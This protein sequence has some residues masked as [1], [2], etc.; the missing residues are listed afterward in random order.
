MSNSTRGRHRSGRHSAPKKKAASP[1]SFTALAGIAGV[2]SVIATGGSALPT[3]N[4]AVTKKADD[5][6]TMIPVVQAEAISV[7]AANRAQ[8]ASR[9]N[10]RDSLAEAQAAAQASTVADPAADLNAVIDTTPTLKSTDI[11]AIQ[12][13]A[14]SS[15]NFNLLV[16]QVQDDANQRAQLLV[17][18]QE[19]ARATAAE[20]EAKVAAAIEKAARAKQAAITQAQ[21]IE[22][23]GKVTIPI[24]EGYELSARFWQKGRIWSGGVHTGLDFRVPPGTR[25]Y[26]AASGTVLESGYEGSYGYRVVIDHGDGYLTTYNHMSKSFVGIGAFIPAGTN[27]G[28]SGSTGNTTGP[29]L[30]FEVMKD[31][32]FVNPAGWLWGQG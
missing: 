22:T 7:A 3:V 25:V 24:Q 27:I 28:L 19:I 8:T 32:Q 11:R 10:E 14:T 12:A 16:S 20:A 21:R 4:S 31:G 1:K 26:S 23:I 15:D 6:T 5:T 9:S 2:G 17:Q 29:H 13:L 30:H 18:Q